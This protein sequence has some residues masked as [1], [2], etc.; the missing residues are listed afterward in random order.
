M[1]T[2][3][4]WS[5]ASGYTPTGGLHF[6][7]NSAVLGWSIAYGSGNGTGVTFV[8]DLQVG[9]VTYEFG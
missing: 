6:D 8:D 1:T 9:A 2:F 3:S 7:E 4:D 5:D